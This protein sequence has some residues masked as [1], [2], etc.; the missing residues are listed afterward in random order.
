MCLLQLLMAAAAL[1]VTESFRPFYEE[2]YRYLYNFIRK[3]VPEEETAQDLTQEAFTR[4]LKNWQRC[5]DG[6]DRKNYLF[7]TAANLCRDHARSS[8]QKRGH[9]PLEL[10]AGSLADPHGGAAEHRTGL[11]Q[12]EAVLQRL[13]AALPEEERLVL[14]LKR[15]EGMT[16]EDIS[17]MT[18]IP[19]RTLKRRVKSTL[20]SLVAAL[21]RM[22]I[23]AEEVLQ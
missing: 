9:V 13:L 20:D 18:R 3:M 11:E 17:A 15:V 4:V 7:T 5:T 12:L 10:V 16:Y 2:Y 21:D 23:L 6:K 14:Q 19:V 1:G 22:G 8:R